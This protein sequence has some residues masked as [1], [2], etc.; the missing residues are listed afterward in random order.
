[1]IETLISAIV[2]SVVVQC[3]VQAIKKCIKMESGYSLFNRI[4]IKVLLSV[5][6]SIL[7]CILGHIDIL[8]LLGITLL[9][10]VIGEIV[11]GIICSSGANVIRDLVKQIEQAKS[12][13]VVDEEEE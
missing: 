8:G 11:T 12:G 2:I 9:I 7:L 13:E 3:I 1:M 5:I 4:N 6:L 10:P